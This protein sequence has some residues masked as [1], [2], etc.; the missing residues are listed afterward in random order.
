VCVCACVRACVEG[1]NVELTNFTELSPSKTLS[2][3]ATEK[4]PNILWNPKVHYRVH[5][6]HSAFSILSQINSVHITPSSLRYILILSSRLRLRLLSG[7]FPSSYPTKILH[8]FL[9]STMRA[10][11]PAHLIIDLSI[12]LAKSTSYEDSHY[13]IFSNILSLYLSSVQIFS[14]APCSQTP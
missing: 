12:L 13:A 9:F 14:S 3:S 1:E 6:S 7:L 10:T 8:A 5:K 4:F 11:C 2:R